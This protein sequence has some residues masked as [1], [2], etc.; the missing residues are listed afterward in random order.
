MPDINRFKMPREKRPLVD[1]GW[2]VDWPHFTRENNDLYFWLTP[3]GGGQW[4]VVKR[5]YSSYY[6]KAKLQ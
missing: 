4:F 2:S 1:P 6:R 3:K 5:D